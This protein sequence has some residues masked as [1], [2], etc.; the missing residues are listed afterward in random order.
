MVSTGKGLAGF[1][2]D[3]IGMGAIELEYRWA[4]VDLPIG[5]TAGRL[6]K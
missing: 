3:A 1:G 4:A 2:A 6:H 5:D